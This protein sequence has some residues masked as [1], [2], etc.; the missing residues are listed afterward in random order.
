MPKN[1]HSSRRGFIATSVTG[2]SAGLLAG[3]QSAANAAT[4]PEQKSAAAP[5]VRYDELLPH[6]FRKRLAERPIAY[7]PLGTLEWHGEHLPLSE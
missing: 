7:L 3:G 5:K 6:E 1:Q 4:E 2:V